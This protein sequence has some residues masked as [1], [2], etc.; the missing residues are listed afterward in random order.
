MGTIWAFRYLHCHQL[1][2][3]RL[4]SLKFMVTSLVF[5][6]Y[7]I[8][9]C[10]FAN[11]LTRVE[12]R[13]SKA[14][15]L[16]KEAKIKRISDSVRDIRE[17]RCSTNFEDEVDISTI[18]VT[19]TRDDLNGYLH[20]VDRMI[21]GKSGNMILKDQHVD[22]FSRYAYAILYIILCLYFRY[23]KIK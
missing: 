2:Q 4:G 3:E 6:F 9:E 12:R 22:I 14:C 7:S 21:V 13:V 20:K 16:A 19:L 10:I 11:Y 23:E 17:S 15:K 5:N 18:H 8:I 1:V